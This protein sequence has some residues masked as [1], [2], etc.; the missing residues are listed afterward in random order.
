MKAAVLSLAA[1]LLATPAVAQDERRWVFVDN[2]DSVH[3]GYGTPDSDDAVA[4]F[5]CAKGSNRAELHLTVEHRI[6]TD[7]PTADGRWLDAKGRPE[8]WPVRLQLAGRTVA[9]TAT[10]DE[11]NGGSTVTLAAAT[12]D[13][14]F[15]AIGKAGR[16]RAEAFGETVAP[17][18]FR[19]ADFQRFLRGCKG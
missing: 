2:A 13:P 12:S 7:N 10:T 8:P 16:L 18:P 9:A 4:S 3:L 11:M 19:K 1:L 6:A 17:P 15:A 14:A 5:S